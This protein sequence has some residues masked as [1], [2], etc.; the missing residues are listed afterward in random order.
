MNEQVQTNEEFFQ[1]CITMQAGWIPLLTYL[2]MYPEETKTAIQ[3]RIRREVWLRGVHY[4]TPPHGRMWV[5]VI[6]I[7]KW[8]GTVVDQ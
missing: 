8:A 5:N 4:N 7:G 6:A 1:S 3:T 2:R